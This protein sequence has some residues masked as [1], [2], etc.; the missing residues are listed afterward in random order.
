MSLAIRRANRPALDES[1]YAAGVLTSVTLGTGIRRE[2]KGRD[3]EETEYDRYEFAFDVEGKTGDPIEITVHTGT[4][5]ND[6][7]V[8]T[9]GKAR[10]KKNTVKIYNRFTSMCIV[11][12][13]ISEEELS[14]VTTERLKETQHKLQ[15]LKDLKT[16][17]KVGRNEDGYFV[18]DIQSLKLAS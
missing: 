9:L 12:G 11:L 16:T 15:T 5:I 6:E 8:K 14:D 4:V 17:F 18:I 1:G 2:K 13:L 3:I 7:P 10:G